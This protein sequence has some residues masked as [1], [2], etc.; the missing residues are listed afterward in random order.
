MLTQVER[1]EFIDWEKEFEECIVEYASDDERPA[2]QDPDFINHEK[3]EGSSEEDIG[4]DELEPELLQDP[5]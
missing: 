4:H 5:V 2:K 1:Q 3:E